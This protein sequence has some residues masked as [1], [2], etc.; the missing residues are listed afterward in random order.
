MKVPGNTTLYQGERGW[1]EL[2]PGRS[3]DRDPA[4][5]FGADIEMHFE[6]AY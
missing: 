6:Q 2:Q 4:Y 3:A 5:N 1:E